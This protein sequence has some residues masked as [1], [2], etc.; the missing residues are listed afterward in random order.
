MSHDTDEP[1]A[2]PD[3]GGDDEQESTAAGRPSIKDMKAKATDRVASTRADL[4]RRRGSSAAIDAVFRSWESDT[5]A[6]GGVLAGAVAF[7]IFL[8]QIPFTFFFVTLLGAFN[9][10]A[11][12]G[13][14]KDRVGIGG[15]TAKAISTASDLSGWSRVAALVAAGFATFLAA[16]ALV[17]VLWSVHF[18]LWRLPHTKIRNSNAAAVTLIGVVCV[19]LVL[20]GL[21]GLLKA[22]TVIGGILL[23]IL[24]DA[25][26]GACWLLVSRRLPH[27]EGATWKDLIPGGVMFGVGTM[28]L[29]LT[30]VYW[31]SYQLKSKSET[32]GAIGASLALLLWAYIF[33]RIITAAAVVNHARWH[34]T[35]ADPVLPPPA[36]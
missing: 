17:K 23:L 33:G 28:V 27:A 34:Q 36:P 16:R 31:I 35:H 10:G 1:T 18:L 32:Y 6:G 2:P 13:D 11:S 4:E 19:A 9:D 20:S 3:A 21:V 29:H 5:N 15:L 8:F 14:V 26:F 24:S 30:T 25:I 12:P 7:R 22:E